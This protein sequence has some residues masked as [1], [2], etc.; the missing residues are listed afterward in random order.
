MNRC[1]EAA[2]AWLNAHPRAKQWLWFALLWLGG[3]AAVSAI[4]YPI[5]FAM[6]NM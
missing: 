2:E 3:L 6:Q 5:K 4:A 1:I